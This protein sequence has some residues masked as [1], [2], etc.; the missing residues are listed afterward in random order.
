MKKGIILSFLL[1]I[2]CTNPLSAQM[3]PDS[4]VHITAYWEVGDT[5]DYIVSQK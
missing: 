1:S 4:T 5:A 3:M 2:L